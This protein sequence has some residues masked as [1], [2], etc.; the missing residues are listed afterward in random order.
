MISIDKPQNRNRQNTETKKIHLKETFKI[1]Q[2]KEYIQE[3]NTDNI[4]Q[5]KYFD[6]Y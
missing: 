6:Y 5:R 4:I 3:R 1:I 2:I